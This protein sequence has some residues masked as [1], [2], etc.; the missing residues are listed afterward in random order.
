MKNKINQKFIMNMA[1]IIA[2][3]ICVG[4]LDMVSLNYWYKAVIKFALFLVIP[5][6]LLLY[7]KEKIWNLLK[8]DKKHIGL[9][10]L[11]GLLTYGFIVAGYF[12][13]KMFIDYSHI[14]AEL[15]KSMGVTKDNFMMV[16]LYIPLVNALIEE[17]FFRGFI[18]KK[19]EPMLGRNKV[20][21][22]S[23]SLFS[24]Y[25]IAIFNAWVNAWVVI[26]A[27]LGLFLV[28]ILFSYISTKTKSILPTYIIHFCANLGINTA[29]LFILGIL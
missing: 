9:S 25:H 1:I 23:A 10:C 7:A 8:T 17:F 2:I 24:I 27:V 12:V 16:A 5:L 26:G 20:V 6:M 28:G 11:L 4:L 22:I 3:L 18:H 21:F 14:P 19:L 29:A 15:E 13:T